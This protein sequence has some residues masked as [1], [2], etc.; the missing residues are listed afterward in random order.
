MQRLIITSLASVFLMSTL[1]QTTEVSPAGGISKL[2]IHY[3][4]IDFTKEQRTQLEQTELELIYSIDERGKPVLEKVNGISDPAIVDS[5]I[6]QTERVSFFNPQIVDGKPEASVYFMKLRFPKYYSNVSIGFDDDIR[7]FRKARHDDFES[8]EYKHS[9]D[10][11]IGGMLNAYGGSAQ[12]HLNTG[13]GMKV[14]MLFMGQKNWGGGF[15]MDF[16]GNKLKKPY[17]ISSTRA[18]TKAPPTLL[19]GGF[20]SKKIN[21]RGGSNELIIQV[22]ANMALQNVVTREN[23]LDKDY[24][25]FFGFSPGLVLH[26]NIAIGHE[27]PGLYYFQPVMVRNFINLNVALRPLFYENKAAS[28]VMFEVGISW[29]LR[30][31]FI[32]SYRFK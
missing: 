7:Q 18:Q 31:Q 10:I 25:Q 16:Y 6:R 29:R 22:D 5:L 3:Y 9:M 21:Q 23:N 24:V 19:M 8:I 30:T 4:K 17:P 27:K 2:A 1:A 15:T 13:G 28:G 12:E 26:Y 11:V 14:D 32:D 20:A